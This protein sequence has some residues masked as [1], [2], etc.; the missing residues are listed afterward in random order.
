M[1]H[2]PVAK[3]VLK[4]LCAKNDVTEQSILYNFLDTKFVRQQF[5]R[6]K[7]TDDI[8]TLLSSRMIGDAGDDHKK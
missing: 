8:R 2:L 6:K 7:I 4:Y 1:T 3:Q 5:L